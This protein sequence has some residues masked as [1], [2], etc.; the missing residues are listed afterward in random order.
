MEDIN[1]CECLKDI[2]KGTELYS[3]I[4][5]KV[6]LSGITDINEDYPIRIEYYNVYSSFTIDG[7][8][9]TV[10]MLTFSSFSRL[11]AIANYFNNGWTK[12]INTKGYFIC[13]ADPS[14][15]NCK[16]I[17]S[18]Y[19]ILSH[20]RVVYPCIVYFQTI[21]SAKKAIKIMGDSLEYLFDE[22]KF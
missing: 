21:E 18:D 3:T 19:C 16:A 1:L 20:E 22:Q 2:P 4:Y 7:D 6:S 10:D 8:T 15:I 5:G 14:S 11:K 17:C 9:I 13:K 12:T